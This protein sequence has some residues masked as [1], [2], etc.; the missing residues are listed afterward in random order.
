[1]SSP[2]YQF[3]QRWFD[4]HVP[5]W[6]QIWDHY[7]PQS[8]LE[9]GAFEGRATVWMAE[10]MAAT[11]GEGY[12]QVIDPWAPGQMRPN[13]QPFPFDMSEVHVRFL[14]NMQIARTQYGKNVVL[15]WLR[16]E[17]H[18]GLAYLLRDMNENENTS[19]MFDF[20]YVDGAHDSRSVLEDGLMAFRLLKPGGVIVFDDY[21][22]RIDHDVLHTPRL[23]IELFALVN[24]PYVKPLCMANN[25]AAFERAK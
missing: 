13:G 22:W 2:E 19:G 17:S 11:H 16:E 21:L 9:I 10:R 4:N 14:H 5:T 24:H 7:K 23:G 20:I 1:M 8:V 18:N 15:T 3:T 12:I 6:E 25:Q